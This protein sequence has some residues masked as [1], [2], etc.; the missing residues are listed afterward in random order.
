MGALKK[1]LYT[2]IAAALLLAGSTCFLF[3]PLVKSAVTAETRFL[4]WDVP[5]QY[6]PDLVYLCGALH[7]G[8]LPYWNP[9]DRAGYPY[10][11]DPQSGAYH[12]VNW[13]ICAVAGPSPALAWAEARVLLGFFLAGLFGMLWLR[14]YGLPP[15]AALLGAVAIQAAPFMRHNWE[16]NLTTAFAYTPLMLWAAERV[17]TER[18]VRDGA[19]LGLAGALCAW[20]GSPPALWFASTF[21]AAFISWRL[22]DEARS[23]GRAAL[24]RA[25]VVSLVAALLALGFAL[26]VLLPGV[27]LA[28]HSVQAG[29]DFDSISAGGL[30]VRDLWAFVTPQAGNHL[31]PGLLVLT[32]AATAVV[33]GRRGVAASRAV[34]PSTWFFLVI[35]LVAILMALGAEAPLFR[36]AHDWIPGVSTFRLPHR[37]E[38]WLGPALGALAAAGL[39]QLS[40][41]GVT[42]LLL[43]H[44]KVLRGITIGFVCLGVLT[45]LLGSSPS[46][47]LLLMALGVIGVGASVRELGT[48]HLVVGAALSFLLLL[49]VSQSMPAT[50]HTR[51]GPHPGGE[52]AAAPVLDAAPG[53]D[54][55]YRYFD[56]FGVSCRSGTR[57]GRRDFRGYQDPLLLKSYERVVASLREQP[58]LLEQYNVRYVLTGAHFIHGWDR[59]YLPPPRELL[60][61]EGARERGEGVVELA[62]ALSAAYWVPLDRVAVFDDRPAALRQVLSVAPSPV[63]ILEESG[64]DDGRL[65]ALLAA[66]NGDQ[67]GTELSVAGR[68]FELHRDRL[69]VEIEA[70]ASGMI[71]INEAWYPGWRAEVDGVATPVHRVN[72]LVRG[73]FV[74]AGAHRVEMFFRPPEGVASRWL[75]LA[76]WLA[77]MVVLAVPSV[78]RK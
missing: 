13:A 30:N 72:A 35:A 24:Y 62:G 74:E 36:F 26:V 20:V 77:F 21:T 38:A 22:V 78:I 70:P 14:R 69:A 53:T 54:R 32:L 33:C 37:Y 59:H 47:G 9:Y 11:A 25:L 48:T 39:T 56:E 4:E 19:L 7:D 12:P 27:S 40:G 41:S 64:D 58:R 28:E 10:Y 31:Y 16:L 1:N 65:Q 50:R 63:A 17:V 6:W 42:Q 60:E 45:L 67:R 34:L 23:Q 75:L 66:A 15:G 49:D 52:D 73:V 5:E 8:E 18:R 68:A 3:A 43:R 55:E 46:M 29:H 51:E 44:S 76:S 61:I 71:V 57:F 2:T